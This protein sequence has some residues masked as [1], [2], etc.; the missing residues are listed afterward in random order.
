MKKVSII[1]P[2]YNMENSI[3]KSVDSLLNQSYKQSEII[4]IDDGSTDET[5]KKCREI[6]DKNEQVYVIHSENQGSGPARNIGIANA[7]GDYAYFPDADDILDYRSIELLVKHME[8]KTNHMVVFGF[9]DVTGDG[10]ILGEKRYKE[11][12]FSGEYIR[13]HYDQF[14]SV[15]E[16]YW[17][18]GAPWNKLFDL[19]IIKN[20]NIL[21][22]ALRR[23]QDEVFISRY[24]EK[25][26]HV[27]F[28]N[29]VLYSYYTNDVKREWDK[30]P[31]DYLD[32]A[33]KLREFRLTIIGNWNK[34]N[35]T[36]FE[37]IDQ[38]FIFNYVKG[39]E[40]SFSKKMK[41]SPRGRRK[42]IKNRINQDQF[43]EIEMP[44]QA[45]MKYQN[46][47]LNLIHH[48]HMLRL[49]CLLKFK[50]F[51]QKNSFFAFNFAKR[52]VKKT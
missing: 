21:F 39:L 27:R 31:I 34:E 44:E 29:D 10:T 43:N 22:P 23:H 14:L 42:W 5:L 47:V 26:D 45:E 33:L 18:Q 37:L 32:I 28:I 25:V 24:I 1:V 49:Y 38:E 6:E 2:I 19:S 11:A 52:L 20:H 15:N 16:T 12:D 7:T 36:V 30:Y 48:D 40:L 41:F 3:E 35:K 17:I 46:W 50:V 8:D 13:E 51:I 4:L 9:K